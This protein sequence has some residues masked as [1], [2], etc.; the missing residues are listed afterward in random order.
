MRGQ[1]PRQQR[2]LLRRTGSGIGGTGNGVRYGVAFARQREGSCAL[3]LGRELRV[4]AL[5]AKAFRFVLREDLYC[6]NIAL[7]VNGHGSL[8]IALEAF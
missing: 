6:G 8:H 1:N 4:D 5:A 7:G 3:I 2:L